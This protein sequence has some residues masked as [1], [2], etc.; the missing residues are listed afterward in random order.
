MKNGTLD[1]ETIE[2]FITLCKLNVL[3]Q[4]MDI[5]RESNEKLRSKLKGLTL[6]DFKT[7][8]LVQM[9]T[10]NIAMQFNKLLVKEIEEETKSRGLDSN[11]VLQ[12]ALPYISGD[13][14]VIFELDSFYNLKV[15]ND[16]GLK[17]VNME[18]VKQYY[19]KT[20][21]YSKML[22]DGKIN[23]QSAMVFPSMMGHFL[24]NEFEIHNIQV[25]DFT[26]NYLKNNSDNYDENFIRVLFKEIFFSEKGRKVI[27]EMME[28][29]MA[30]M[31]QLMG[32]GPGGMPPMD[33]GMMGMPPMDPGM[34][35]MPPMDPGMGMPPMPP[36]M[37][38]NSM[39]SRKSLFIYLIIS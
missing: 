18:N 19:A 17:E 23:P 30:M 6:T 32:G 12:Q 8:M 33:P 22:I 21:E 4:I 37:D 3:E 34:M 16:E 14:N 20:V 1:M 27:F 26:D 13:M 39:P 9:S 7:S 10:G 11:K 38:P 2:A 15:K 25:L 28:A 31:S 24:Y 5:M 35:G 29:Q 36:G